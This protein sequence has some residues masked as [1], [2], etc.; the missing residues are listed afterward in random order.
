MHLISSLK[1][2][3]KSD[4]WFDLPNLEELKFERLPIVEFKD[5]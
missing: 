4:F 2:E 5:G 3:K 1:T